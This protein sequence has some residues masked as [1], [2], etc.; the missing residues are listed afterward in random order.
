MNKHALVLSTID[1]K[2]TSWKQIVSRLEQLV[3]IKEGDWESVRSVIQSLKDS[4]LISRT[5]DLRQEVYIK[6]CLCLDCLEKEEE[7]LEVKKGKFKGCFFCKECL[8]WRG[9]SSAIVKAYKKHIN[10]GGK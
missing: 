2:G 4:N 6:N 3:T 9:L 7:M 1:V 10:E 5:S 8:N